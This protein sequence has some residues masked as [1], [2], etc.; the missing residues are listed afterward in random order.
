LQHTDRRV[1]CYR[2]DAQ[3]LGHTKTVLVLLISWLALGESMNAR[4]AAGMAVAVSGMV[5]YGYCVSASSSAGSSSSASRKTSKPGGEPGAAASG[6]NDS[7]AMEMLKGGGSKGAMAAAAAAG[8]DVEEGQEAMPL[9]QNV[10]SE[11]AGWAGESVMVV[12][13]QQ[14]GGS[15][16]G[17]GSQGAR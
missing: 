5:A 1:A 7:N 9:L 6:A 10:S 16:D 14:Q 2:C 3:V 4:K 17:S 12:S 15:A 8:V 11:H 13:V